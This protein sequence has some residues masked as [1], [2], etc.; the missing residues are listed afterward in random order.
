MIKPGTSEVVFE[1]DLSGS[2]ATDEQQ[3]KGGEKAVKAH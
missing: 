1:Q 2:R 3:K